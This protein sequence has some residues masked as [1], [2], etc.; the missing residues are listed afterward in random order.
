MIDHTN[1][2]HPCLFCWSMFRAV[3]RMSLNAGRVRA[4]VVDVLDVWHQVPLL[5]SSVGKKMSRIGP[6]FSYDGWMIIKLI[7]HW[8]LDDWSNSFNLLRPP[9]FAFRMP[10]TKALEISIVCCCREIVERKGANYLGIILLDPPRAGYL[11]PTKHRSPA[12]GAAEHRSLRA[13]GHQVLSRPTHGGTSGTRG[14][15]ATKTSSTN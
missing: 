10:G 12:G 15:S 6:W 11:T 7:F 14:D 8:W 1:I 2:Y 9:R 13:F 3:C 4:S 5:S